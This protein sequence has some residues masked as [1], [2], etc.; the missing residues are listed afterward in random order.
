M[1]QTA[2]QWQRRNRA[3]RLN[4]PEL[5]PSP[6]VCRGDAAHAQYKRVGFMQEPASCALS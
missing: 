3:E 5:M 6:A 2:E 4:A 1:I